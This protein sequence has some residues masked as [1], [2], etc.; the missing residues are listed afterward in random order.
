MRIRQPC[1]HQIRIHL[2][3]SR[4]T[5]PGLFFN[6]DT[7]VTGYEYPYMWAVFRYGPTLFLAQLAHVDYTLNPSHATSS[8]RLPSR[9]RLPVCTKPT[10]PRRAAKPSAAAIAE[11]PSLGEPSSIS[12]VNESFVPPLLFLS[13][14]SDLVAHKLLPLPFH[15]Q[16]GRNMMNVL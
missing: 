10:P 9:R 12:N 4:N 3:Y 1:C 16:D 14:L 11:L 8:C 15:S 7:Y 6:L 2:G 13:C 5:Y